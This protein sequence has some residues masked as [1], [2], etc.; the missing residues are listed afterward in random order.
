MMSIFGLLVLLSSAAG[1]RGGGDGIAT[2][3]D[4]SSSRRIGRCTSYM[5]EA[6]VRFGIPESWIRRVMRA[7]SGGRAMLH[8]QP[9]ASSAGAMGLMQLMPRTWAEMRVKH[10]LGPDPHHPR[11]NILAGAAYLRAMYDRFGY[12]GLFA[13]YNAGPARYAEHLATG[14]RLPRET[15]AYVG[16]VG[17]ELPRAATNL[18]TQPPATGIFISRITGGAAAKAVASP[19]ADA[20]FIPLGTASAAGE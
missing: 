2:Q 12:P 7:E 16:A 13:A 1:G 17:L 9:I 19:G 5:E 8:G 3:A 6:S 14:R 20:L 11:D 10:G 4:R 15:L 18:P